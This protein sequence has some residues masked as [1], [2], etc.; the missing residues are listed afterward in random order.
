MVFVV[1]LVGV[2]HA[3]QPDTLAQPE[4]LHE[5]V[6]WDVL[7]NGLLMIR[8]DRTG[9]GIPDHVALHQVTWSGWTA[10]TIPD[11]EAQA[12]T[13]RQRVFI[14]EYDQDRYVY[15]T[16]AEPLL[17]GDDAQQD[18][19]WTAQPAAALCPTCAE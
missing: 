1:C 19:R 5:P 15:L 10:Q 9:D 8:Y 14:V 6:D 13:D 4:N 3:V 18:G 16:G 7:P 17:V 2:A 12:A 11:I